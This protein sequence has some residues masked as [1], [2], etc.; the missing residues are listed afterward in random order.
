MVVDRQHFLKVQN[1]GDSGNHA[2]VRKQARESGQASWPATNARVS[3]QQTRE[4]GQKK[5]D[6]RVTR[7]KTTKKGRVTRPKTTKRGR[8]TLLTQRS[9]ARWPVGPLARWPSTS[10]MDST[11]SGTRIL[12]APEPGFFLA[13]SNFC[14]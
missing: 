8:V 13:R 7:P 1:K 14:V 9:S 5:S 3:R 10:V 4:S 6:P 12:E 11:E 2:R